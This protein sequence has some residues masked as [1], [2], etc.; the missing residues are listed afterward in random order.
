MINTHI[1]DIR[2]ESL[3]K[4][5]VGPPLHGDQVTEP[6]VSELVRYVYGHV[7]LVSGHAFR[8][9]KQEGCFSGDQ[10]R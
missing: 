5:E 7:L 8:F 1:L 10:G 9:I 4:P 2:R 6:L 3:V